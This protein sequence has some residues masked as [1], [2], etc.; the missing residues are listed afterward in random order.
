L[1][2]RRLVE[3]GARFIQVNFSRTVTQKSYG[4]DTHDNGEKVMKGELLPKLNGG[5]STLLDDLAER[6]ML[7]DTLVVAMGEFGRTP[8]VKKGGGR[9][10]WAGCYSALLAG[11]GVKGGHVHGKSDKVAAHPTENP[12]EARDLL[13]TILT[14]LGVPTFGVDSFGR[15]APLFEGARVVDEIFA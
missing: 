6:G 2:A 5:L 3:G 8:R 14:L 4:W 11:G 7:R 9:D 13:M 12:V 15:A 1:L 10:H